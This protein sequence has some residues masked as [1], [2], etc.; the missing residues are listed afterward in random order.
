M[1]LL[2][3][4]TALSRLPVGGLGSLQ[5]SFTLQFLGPNYTGRLPVAHTCFNCLQLGPFEG[6]EQMRGAL[7]TAL[8]YGAEGFGLL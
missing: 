1:R 7:M 6:E 8:A 2:Q 3:F 4:V 5:P